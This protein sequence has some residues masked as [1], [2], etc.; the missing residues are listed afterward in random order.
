MDDDTFRDEDSASVPCQRKL[1]LRS[2]LPGDVSAWSLTKDVAALGRGADCYV[3]VQHAGVSRLHAEIRR[4]G[5]LFEIRDLGSTNGTFVDGVRAEHRELAEGAV[6]RLG[7]WLGVVEAYPAEEAGPYHFRELAPG[8]WGGRRLERVLEPMLRAASSDVPVAL[9]GRT[10]TGKERFAQALHECGRQGRAFHA[11]N[12]AALPPTLA[13]AE[14]FGYRKGAFTGA[15]RNH[16]G[17]LRLAHG[18]TLLL[19]EV[20]DLPLSLQAKLLRA[21]DTGEIA[22]IGEGSQAR[23][24]ARIVAAYQVPPA[25]LVSAGR[26]REDLAARLA[27]LIVRLPEL[28]ERRGD[29]PA[30]FDHF[31]RV[32]SGGTAPAVT[33]RVYERLCLHPWAANVRELELLARQMLAVHG[34]ESTLHRSHLPE[35]LSDM[36]PPSSA[37]APRKASHAV[38]PTHP[39]E[40]VERLTVA[41]EATGGNVKT[42]AEL[43]GISRQRAYRLIASRRLTPLVA[44]SRHSLV[45]SDH[46]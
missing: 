22:P 4:H 28:R 25:E 3:Q 29:V 35:E 41:L 24:A 6:V 14:L 32:H 8:V 30:L 39:V 46:D 42:A 40:E 5:P 27:G 45:A 19:D 44:A 34:L 16:L 36:P 17:H 43:A 23:F 2:V 18:G 11:V 21:L 37:V 15:E 13:E 38:K 7:E 1:V 26:F 10:G 31:L 20:A 33:T 12:C 9:V